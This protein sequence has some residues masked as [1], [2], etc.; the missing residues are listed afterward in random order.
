MLP[1]RHP[2]STH[3]KKTWRKATRAEIEWNDA[4]A[5]CSIMAGLL[6]WLLRDWFSTTV[7]IGLCEMWRGL[8][9]LGGSGVGWGPVGRGS[10]S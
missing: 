3:Q 10:R 8:V 9:G 7:D 6:F 5:S 4:L 2:T 1:R